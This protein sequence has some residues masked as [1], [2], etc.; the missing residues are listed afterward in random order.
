MFYFIPSSDWTASFSFFFIGRYG[1]VSTEPE[2]LL[3]G[4]LTG[5][6]LAEDAN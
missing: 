6:Y 2:E 3:R 5:K 1:D 4:R